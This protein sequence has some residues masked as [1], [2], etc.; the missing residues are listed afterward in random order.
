M[1]LITSRAFA[2]LRRIGL[3]I[4]PPVVSRVV[5]RQIVRRFGPTLQPGQIAGVRMPPAVVR[6][7][8]ELDDAIRCADEAGAV[9]DDA[10]RQVLASFR[11]EYHRALPADPFS[12]GYRQAQFEIYRHISGRESYDAARDEATPIR[13]EDMLQHPFPYGTHSTH[14]IGEQL[15]M[16]GFVMR[17]LELKA[18]ASVLEFGPGWGNT[19][20]HLAQGGFK[21][22][23][24]DV[25]GDYLELIQRRAGQ[26]GATVETVQ[27][28]MLDFHTDRRFDAVLF[29]ECFHHCADHLRMLR[30]LHDLVT[31]DGVV[32]FGAEPIG[33]MTMPWGIR[34]DGMSV[35]SIRKFGWFELGFEPDYFGAA[36]KRTGWSATSM[37]SGDVPHCSVF[38]ARKRQR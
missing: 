17:A 29:F 32:V 22:T 5:S 36:L 25:F 27:R 8:S 6:N 11:Y 13:V 23:A 38:V 15:I 4:L 24:V 1:S 37:V 7:H 26:I 12:E 35:W 20:L 9:S 28:D 10:L 19:T 14:T 3:D 18:G 2:R 21:V 16:Q 30:Q 34:M 33:P 31:D